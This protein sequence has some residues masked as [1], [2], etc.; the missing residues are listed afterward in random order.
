M[1]ANGFGTSG[2]F[3]GS[4][5]ASFSLNDMENGLPLTGAV[6][7]ANLGLLRFPRIFSGRNRGKCRHPE[8]RTISFVTPVQPLMKCGHLL[9]ARIVALAAQ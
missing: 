6:G 1:G 9:P 4:I 7:L 3:I 2:G 8:R 5:F